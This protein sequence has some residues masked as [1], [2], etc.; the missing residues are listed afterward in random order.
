MQDPTGDTVQIDATWETAPVGA[1]AD[2][3][4]D[5]CSQGNCTAVVEGGCAAELKKTCGGLG[6]LGA[7]CNDCVYDAFSDL[8]GTCSYQEMLSYCAKPSS[9]N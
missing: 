1:A 4:M 6:G 3:L 9:A 2:A 8:R 5:M 7:P